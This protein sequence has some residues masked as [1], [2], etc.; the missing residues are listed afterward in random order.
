[1]TINL[2]RYY[3]VDK[4]SAWKTGIGETMFDIEL[5]SKSTGE[6]IVWTFTEALFDELLEEME[7]DNMLM[8]SCL[9]RLSRLHE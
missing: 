3:D 5:V 8:Q 2:T 1:M 9:V 7:I 6:I 4:V